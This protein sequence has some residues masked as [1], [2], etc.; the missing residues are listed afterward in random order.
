MTEEARRQVRRNLAIFVTVMILFLTITAIVLVA[1][2]SVSAM[3][4]TTLIEADG[5]IEINSVIENPTSKAGIDIR[6]KGALAYESIN[7]LQ[8]NNLNQDFDIQMVA[9]N[10]RFASLKAVTAL[11]VQTDDINYVYAVLA[12]A[13]KGEAAYLSGSFD[14]DTGETVE[15]DVEIETLISHGNFRNYINFY[16]TESELGLREAIYILGQVYYLDHLVIT[17]TFE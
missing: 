8:P 17:P 9:S 6:G 5:T 1:S 11:Q 7:S 15:I 14:V 2:C 16:N 10:D 12:K 3:N 4:R 13:A